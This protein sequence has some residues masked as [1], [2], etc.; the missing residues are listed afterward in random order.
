MNDK[1]LPLDRYPHIEFGPPEE[2]GT[3]GQSQSVMPASVTDRDVTTAVSQNGVTLKTSQSTSGTGGQSQSVTQVQ[4][5]KKCLMCGIRI[6]RRSTTCS[7]NCRKAASRRKETLNRSL[8]NIL[9]ELRNLQRY[10]DE[11]PDLW[12]EIMSAVNQAGVQAGVTSRYVAPKGDSYP[13]R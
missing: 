9:W 10:A 13:P 8:G 3:S 11:W 7:D 1:P 5:T 12:P 2:S 4:G 6:T